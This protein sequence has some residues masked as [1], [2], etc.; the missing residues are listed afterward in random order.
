MK[1]DEIPIKTL[2]SFHRD[3]VRAKTKAN[4]IDLLCER[5]S[6]HGWFSNMPDGLYDKLRGMR[7][8]TLQQNK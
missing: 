4:V 3:L 5:G 7:S 1:I 8:S 2:D 6:A